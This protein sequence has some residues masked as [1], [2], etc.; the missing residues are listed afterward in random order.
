NWN[1]EEITKLFDIV[2]SALHERNVLILKKDTGAVMLE[3]RFVRKQCANCYYIN[4]L[5]SSE[6]QNCHRCKS[7]FLKDFPS[8]K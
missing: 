4:Y 6:S 1:I 8:R 7:N 2:V 3:S 5:S